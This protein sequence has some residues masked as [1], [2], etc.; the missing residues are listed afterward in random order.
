MPLN[1]YPGSKSQS[2]F[3]TLILY[4]DID[5]NIT[6]GKIQFYNLEMKL[7]D[8]HQPQK[9]DLLIFRGD[10]IH[11]VKNIGGYGKRSLLIVWLN[12]ENKE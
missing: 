7:V 10:V 4:Y 6:D 11:G 1:A 2:K 9:A 5:D 8:E 12:I 3:Y